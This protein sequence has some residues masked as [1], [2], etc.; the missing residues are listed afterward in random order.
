MVINFD[1]HAQLV[2]REIFEARQQYSIA[3]LS[4]HQNRRLTFLG[5]GFCLRYKD[6]PYLITAAH[7]ALEAGRP[8]VIYLGKR[9]FEHLESSGLTTLIPGEDMY[10]LATIPI[11]ED[12]LEKVGIEAVPES[13]WSIR[14]DHPE[15]FHCAI[16]YPVSK[17]KHGKA[18]NVGAKEIRSNLFTVLSYRADV[19]YAKY[20]RNPDDHFAL[21]YHEAVDRNLDRTKPISLRGFSGAPVW[22]THDR[23]AA[24]RPRLAGLLTHHI[25]SAKA[26]FCTRL[27]CVIQFLNTK[28]A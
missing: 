16:G 19:N 26:V 12:M 23:Y 27:A 2:T 7:V 10:D 5:T 13:L 25:A 9:G 14:G 8:G 28:Y 17:N 11:Q 4:E 1:R 3:L 20:G 6:Q 24:G 21:H 15:G 18:I 22:F